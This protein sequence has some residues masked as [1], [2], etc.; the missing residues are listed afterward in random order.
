MTT[1]MDRSNPPPAS[2]GRPLTGSGDVV[3]DT[4]APFRTDLSDWS[5]PDRL[6]KHE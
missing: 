1:G 2:G 4:G 6:D 5:N 3:E